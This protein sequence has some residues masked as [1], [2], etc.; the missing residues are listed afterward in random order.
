MYESPINLTQQK[1]SSELESQIDKD[2]YKTVTTL[3]IDVNKEEL[4]KALAYDREQYDKGYYDGLEDGKI[5]CAERHAK[6]YDDGYADAKIIY[7]GRPEFERRAREMGLRLKV[8]KN[9]NGLINPDP[10]PG[11]AM[12]FSRDEYNHR[13]YCRYEVTDDFFEHP[14]GYVEV[15][16]RVSGQLDCEL[17][18]QLY[19]NAGFDYGFNE[20]RTKMAWYIK[21]GNVALARTYLQECL[22]ILGVK[23]SNIIAE[24]ILTVR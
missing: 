14:E 24:L 11:Y 8:E 12:I 15:L 9:P 2:I 7:T 20:S 5:M 1:I 22:D 13:A 19:A 4:L 10:K 17:R 3:G 16:R 23:D 18:K 6:G 21:H